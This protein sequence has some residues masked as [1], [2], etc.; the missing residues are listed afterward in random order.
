MIF[1]LTAELGSTC[2]IQEF[3]FIINFNTDVSTFR[4]REV[5]APLDL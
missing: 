4:R 5:P 1:P 3:G 2:K